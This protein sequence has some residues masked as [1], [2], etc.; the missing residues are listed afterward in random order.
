MVQIGKD[1]RVEAS[2]YKGRFYVSI[3]KWYEKEGE[4]KPSPKGITMSM[5]EWMELVGKFDE[6]KADVV[7]EIGAISPGA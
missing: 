2:E 5:D 4:W 1:I 3:R 6:I 7:K